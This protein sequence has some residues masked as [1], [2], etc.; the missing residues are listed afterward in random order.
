MLD[1]LF[2]NTPTATYSIGKNETIPESFEKLTTISLEQTHSANF[3]EVTKAKSKELKD[4]DAA[5]TSL[6]NLHLKVKHADCLPILLY[7]PKPIIGV[8]HAG[9]KGS[10]SGILAA[11]LTYLKEI[12]KI[13]DGI[14]LW[15][16]PAICDRC[17]QINEAENLH[18]NLLR[19]NLNQVKAVFP[20]GEVQIAFANGCTVH[21]NKKYYS[22]RAEGPGVQMN[23]SGICL[24]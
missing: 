9:R 11:V 19:A 10:E 16:G 17:Y 5:L 7:H 14:Q 8:I 23:W 1:T 20:N 12:H 15:F 4:C 18:Y 24:K 13:K 21:Q 3:E 2:P 22:Y 6:P